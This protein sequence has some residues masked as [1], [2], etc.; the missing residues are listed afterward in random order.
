MTVVL[1]MAIESV[2]AATPARAP[3]RRGSRDVDQRVYDVVSEGYLEQFDL[4]WLDESAF[5]NTQALAM[6]RAEAE[7]RGSPPSASWRRS[8]VS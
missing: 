4:V 6:K 5:N 8:P 3:P 1:G 7:A 2:A